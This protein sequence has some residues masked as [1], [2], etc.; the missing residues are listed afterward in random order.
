M[1]IRR[2]TKNDEDRL[3]E[4]IEAEGEEWSCYTSPGA[5]ARYRVLLADS[6]TYVA[7]NGDMICGY[8]RSIRDGDFYIYVCDLLVTGQ[9]RGQGLG[10]RLMECVCR[11]H[12][13]TTVYVM[14]DVDAYYKKLG[15]RREGS[16][17]EVGSD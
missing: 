9:S 2:Y 17:F 6:I 7:C 16:I 11:D 5:A 10:R 8:S 12:P 15:Y 1:E 3:M 13:H 14:S 4:L